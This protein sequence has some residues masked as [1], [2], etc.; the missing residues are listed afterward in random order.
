[1][2]GGG[3]AGQCRCVEGADD[4]GGPLAPGRGP[5][6]P[7][8]HPPLTP[9]IQL[10][11]PAGG[12]RVPAQCPPRQQ[13]RPAHRLGRGARGGGFD[14]P[15]PQVVPGAPREP[16][17]QCVGEPGRPALR[18]VTASFVPRPVREGQVA[19]EHRDAVPGGP[20]HG[21]QLGRE[22]GERIERRASATPAVTRGGRERDRCPGLL[23]PEPGQPFLHLGRQLD[24]HHVGL[25][26][27]QQ[28]GQG[29]GQRGRVVPHADEVGRARVGEGR[30][31]LLRRAGRVGRA[32][33]TRSAGSV[34]GAGEA[35]G[36][37]V[38]CV[39]CG[40]GVEGHGR[41]PSR[42]V[43]RSHRVRQVAEPC[44]ARRRTGPSQ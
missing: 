2:P 40:G 24:E 7:R 17:A 6:D 41:Q 23:V 26:P 3:R 36:A 38:R 25:R 31:G 10:G 11:H 4:H 18:G 22:V 12:G 9:Q 32:R 21:G 29:R 19:G 37:R 30:E 20:A 39:Q 8:P 16:G 15:V 44:S 27:V 43:R 28:R 5:R 35:Q 33:D 42:T 34:R 13:R 14:E 1:M